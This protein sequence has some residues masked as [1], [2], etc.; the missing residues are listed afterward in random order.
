[1]RRATAAIVGAAAAAGALAAGVSA[2]AQVEPEP[3][4]DFPQ[5]SGPPAGYVDLPEG[6]PTPV[7]RWLRGIYG[8]RVPVVG[9][10][11]VTG[12]ARIKPFGMWL[13]A[14]FRFI[15]D[16]GRG[17][18]HYI[19]ATLFGRPILAVNERYVDGRALMEIP[20]VGTDQGPRIE[21]AA[22]LGMWAEL[23]SAA[24]S[25]LVT[26]PRVRWHA[27]DRVTAQLDVPLGE[28]QR[29]TFIVR[30]DRATG[31]LSCL[32]AW[33]HRSSKEPEKVLWIAATEPG[34]AVG[35]LGLPAVGT[36][37]WADQAEPWARFVT[38]D[39]RTDVDVSTTIRA[40]GL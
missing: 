26:D 6:L 34:P 17:Y 19:E 13:P 38:E 40:R 28:A 22:N 2:G 10:V 15:H 14:R 8:D 1:M 33:R 9:S 23:A 20:L 36:A 5:P 12:R 32:E 39:L 25:V 24:P 37:T 16:C 29:D 18:R 27:L 31:A 3:F 4:P 30:F 35:P 11:V 7:E 21:Q